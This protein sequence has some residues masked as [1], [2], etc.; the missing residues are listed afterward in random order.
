MSAPIPVGNNPIGLAVTPDGKHVYVTNFLGS[1][2]SVIDTATRAVSATIPVGP[3]PI[4][5]AVTPDGTH[6][7]V[8]N[9]GDDTV[10][11][12]DY[13]DGRSVRHDRRRLQAVRRGGHSRRRH[14]YVADNGTGLVGTG[15][16]GNTVSV[17][18]TATGV[19]SATITV[20]RGPVGVTVT[21]DGKQGLRGERPAKTRCR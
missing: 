5:V 8:S 17:I 14:A 19:V 1:T 13:G 4:L 6:A 11:V 7:Y 16:E 2:V 21:P 20:G 9:Q 18:D 12:I 10:S 15:V 3:L